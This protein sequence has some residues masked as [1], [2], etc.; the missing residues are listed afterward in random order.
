MY[1]IEA[2][3]TSVRTL[4]VA[5]MARLYEVPAHLT[6]AMVGLARESKSSGWWQAYGE[7]IP[8][9]FE[10]YVGL[11][12]AASRLR[13]YE[14][15]LI[16]GL[17]Q[18]PEY[19]AT[20][21]RTRAGITEREMERAVE[22]RMKRQRLLS[23]RDPVAPELEVIVD[24]SVLR[25]PIADPEAMRR[26][27]AHLANACELPNVSVRV[28]PLAAGPHCASVPGAFVILDFPPVGMRP[29]EPTTIYCE[30][31]TGALYLD[32]PSEIAAYADVWQRLGELALSVRASQ[33][34]ISV[35]I[36]ESYDA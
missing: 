12:A 33:E 5:Q 6:E 2:G 13:R 11:E 20:V 35:V 7:V 25:R 9:W 17:L 28:L 32:R 22:L 34:L 8:N 3:Q 15:A 10:L 30:N 31:L 19:A 1:R 18:T 36:K 27:L 23:R 16:P 21:F 29:P 14:P 24:E 26:Q 4:D